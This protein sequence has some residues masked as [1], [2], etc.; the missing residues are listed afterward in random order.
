MDVRTNPVEKAQR[1]INLRNI[2]R[3]LIEL[4]KPRSRI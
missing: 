4:L 3:L 1:E 2:P